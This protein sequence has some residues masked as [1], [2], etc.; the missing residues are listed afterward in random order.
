MPAPRSSA[1]FAAVPQEVGAILPSPALCSLV[2]PPGS[3][4]LG[5]P[6]GMLTL[7][8]VQVAREMRISP[9]AL[10]NRIARG[11]PHPPFVELSRRRRVW[12]ADELY[13][14]LRER[15]QSGPKPLSPYER[16]GLSSPSKRRSKASN[17]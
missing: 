2:K 9:A 4:L 12:L 14:W 15:Q 10:T 7:T 6:G 13:R 3:L 1:G 8:R 16:L 11:D 17:S 5:D